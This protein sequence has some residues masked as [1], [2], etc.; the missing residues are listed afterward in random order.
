MGEYA[1]YNGKEIK[2]GTCEAMYY[3]RYEDRGRVTPLPGNV[4]PCVD[5]G[6]FFRLPF[7][8]E[9]DQHPGS[10]RDHNRGYRLMAK[11]GKYWG[12][13]E[14]EDLE[15]GRIQ[16]KHESGLLLCVPCHHGAKLPE[17]DGIKP[18][19]NGKSWHMELCSVKSML[20]GSLWPVYHC[21]FCR[22]MWSTEWE[23]ILPYCAADKE[24]L[25][26]LEAYASLS[27]PCV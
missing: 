14:P 9:D 13:W 21:R 8:D 16:L 1:K 17:I 10:Y 4:K 11:E 6:L 20:G 22:S 12:N 5:K 27:V 26:R 25:R 24:M 15:P 18:H 23:E 7:P 3:L 2:I 19:W